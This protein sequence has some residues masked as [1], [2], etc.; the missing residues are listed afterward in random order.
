M[1]AFG[2]A[3]FMVGQYEEAAA[4][5]DKAIQMRAGLPPAFRMKAAALGLLGRVA[6]AQEAVGRLLALNPSETLTSLRTYY[7]VAMKKPGCLEALL[8]GMRK[9]GLPEQ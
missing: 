7:E 5:S 9:A 1:V 3:H 6:E 2:W 8:D 4:W